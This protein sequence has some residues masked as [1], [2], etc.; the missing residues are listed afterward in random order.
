MGVRTGKFRFLL[1]GAM[2]CSLFA[3]AASADVNL[4]ANGSFSDIGGATKNYFVNSSNLPGWT[5][6]QDGGY[7][8]C[9]VISGS[10]RFNN[11]GVNN[12][13][14]DLQQSPGNSPD[15]GNYFFMDGD[16]HDPVHNWLYQTITGLTVGDTYQLNFYQ[17]AGELYPYSQSVSLHWDVNFGTTIADANI[18]PS[19][20][21]VVPGDMSDPYNGIHAWE[22]QSMKLTATS[23]SEVLG[24]L[25]IGTPTN[26]PPIAL[27]DGVSLTDL[28]VTPT[29]EPG[30]VALMGAGLAGLFGIRKYSRRRISAGSK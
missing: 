4:V 22:S 26:Q 12:P 29:P 27:L 9:I 3:V 30:Y 25:A 10:S 24:F 17:A 1:M 18:K 20:I 15:G 19:D 7:N 8:D 2:A 11:C 13:I 16:T 6:Q 23:T 21:M 14:Y 5:V 28:G